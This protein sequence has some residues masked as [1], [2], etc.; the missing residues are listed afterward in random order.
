MP[1][2]RTGGRCNELRG[3]RRAQSCPPAKTP[4][5]I[6]AARAALTS[7]AESVTARLEQDFDAKFVDRKRSANL[8]EDER[9]QL[10]ARYAL[11]PERPNGQK[12]GVIAL[13]AE[14]GR[15]P[16]Y[17]ARFLL[18]SIANATPCS[19]PLAHTRECGA[20]K[21]T[22]EVAVFLARACA[23]VEGEITWAEL[24]QLAAQ[25]FDLCLSAEGVRHHCIGLGW[26]ERKRRILPWLSV[27]Q[28]AARKKW[29]RNLR[30]EKF[31]A[32]VDVDEAWFYTVSLHHKV[33]VPTGEQAPTLFCK[34]KT[35]IPKVMFLAAAARPRPGFDGKLG[36]W[37][38]SKTKKA[39]KRSRYHESG[40]EYEVADTM[41]SEKYFEMMT[42]LVFDSIQKAFTGTGVKRVIIQQD[43]ARP[44]TGKGNMS[45]DGETVGK[46]NAA[47]AKL[48][49]PIE[50]RTQPAQ[51]PDFNICD[52]AF[53]RA[54]KC[55]VRKRRR[56]PSDES[57]PSKFHVEQLIKDVKSEYDAYPSE[58]LEEMWQHKEDV[59]NVVACDGGNTYERHH[60]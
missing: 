19:R 46:L 56:G 38:V 4:G 27:E 41:T 52:L 2:G 24:A 33:K 60:S 54:L 12:L 23:D 7:P 35:N 39:Q 47:G 48:P 9:G 11:L 51:S 16:G 15:A 10:L 55:S 45:K 57:G 30:S 29:A 3:G 42:T 43:G 58:K 53:F 40:E 14:F 25:E 37:R 20:Y 59:M 44:H 13:E 8:W 34:S 5:T 18:P 50:V 1:R 32:W 49:I 26:K 21:M 31:T 28:M 6:A 22:E 36:I 17:I